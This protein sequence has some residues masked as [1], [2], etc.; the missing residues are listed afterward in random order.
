MKGKKFKAKN[1]I[2]MVTILYYTKLLIFEIITLNYLL[3][4]LLF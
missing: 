3:L 2:F 4:R 1:T